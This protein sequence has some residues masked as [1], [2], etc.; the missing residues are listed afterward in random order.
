MAELFL[1][2]NVWRMVRRVYRKKR[3]QFDDARNMT[4]HDQ[5][6]FDWLVENGFFVS[7]GDDWFEPTEKAKLAAD[8][9]AYQWEPSRP[10][11]TARTGRER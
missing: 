11:D 8:L 3:F 4:R 5:K 7:M 6:Q 9:G 2:E 1:S 10:V